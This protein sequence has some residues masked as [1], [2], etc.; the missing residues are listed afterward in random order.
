[1]PEHHPYTLL[2]A[3]AIGLTFAFFAIGCAE[4]RTLPGFT[5]YAQNHEWNQITRDQDFHKA[6]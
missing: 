2:I 1:M 3:V 5:P 6:Y 4:T